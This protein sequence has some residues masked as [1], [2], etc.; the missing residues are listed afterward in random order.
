[1]NG[2]RPSS[3]AP[4]ALEAPGVPSN[5]VRSSTTSSARHDDQ[6]RDRARVAAQLAQHAARGRE[7]DARGSRRGPA[8][9]SARN[10]ASTSSRAR[11]GA[12]S[13][14]GVSSASRLAVAHEQQ[15]VA[16]LGLVH[17]VAGD[18]QRRARV[19]ERAERVP[20]SRRSTGSSPTVGSSSTSSSGSPS[21]AV[22]QRDAGLLAARQRRDDAALGAGEPDRRDRRVDVVRAPTPRMAREVVE[23]LAHGEVAVDG[24]RLGHV[25]DAAAQRGAPAGRPSTVTAPAGD[26]LDAD[27]RAHQRGLAA[28]RW[29]EQADDLAGGDG[30]GQGAKDLPPAPDDP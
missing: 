8:S 29:A 10:A 18:E 16:A 23:V 12:S 28:A 30:E 21:S 5:S 20:E 7:R 14:A 9:T 13:S 24:R 17:H 6:Q 2:K 15:P 4:I 27:D 25:A 3:G 26:P 11:V 19:G 22:G 1:M